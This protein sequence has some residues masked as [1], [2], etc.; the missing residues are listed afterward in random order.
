MTGFYPVRQLDDIYMYKQ[1]YGLTGIEVFKTLW[2]D[3]III[4]F[5]WIS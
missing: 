5:T 4:F 1:S 2:S 3:F